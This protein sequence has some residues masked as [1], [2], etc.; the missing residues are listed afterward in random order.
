MAIKFVSSDLNGTLVHQH[1]M[2]DMIRIFKGKEDFEKADIIFKKQTTGTA[3][4]EEAFDV[5]GPLSKGITLRQA[6]EY[7]QNHLKYLNGFEE[8]LEK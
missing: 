2:S 6:I 8:F 7:T 3:T 1:T 4:M 5:A